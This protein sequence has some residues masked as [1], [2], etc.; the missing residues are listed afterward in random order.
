MS[1][2]FKYKIGKVDITNK[3]LTVP[4]GRCFH[5]QLIKQHYL[6]DR[7]FCSWI[8]HEFNSFVTFTYDDN[9]LVIPEG[10]LN[11]TLVP[12]HL[13]GYIDN[14]KHIVEHSFEYFGCGEYGDRFGRPHYHVLFFGLDYKFYEKFF[15]NSWKYGSIKVLPVVQSS[16]NYVSKYLL[17]GQSEKLAKYFDYG[18]EKPFSV[19]SRGLGLRAVMDNLDSLDSDG[20]VTVKGKKISVNRY[21]FNKLVHHSDKTVS[22]RFLSELE[23][24]NDLNR[25]GIPYNLTG[26]QLDLHN[27]EILESSHIADS[28][29]KL[30][31]II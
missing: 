29:N 19:M 17:S 14:L 1:C 30:S 15:A 26:L 4:C 21:Y 6:T 23:H 16:F 27:S 9:N 18:I 28:R 12:S 3:P 25:K 2:L 20:F 22:N 24:E 10:C 5:C 8:Y 31:R 13:R 7:M 11:P